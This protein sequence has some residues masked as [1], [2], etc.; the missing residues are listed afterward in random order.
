VTTVAVD[1]AQRGLPAGTWW[2]ETRDG[3]VAEAAVRPAVIGA[4]SS[5][6]ISGAMW[7]STRIPVTQ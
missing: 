2:V 5:I 6:S 7:Y 1:L 3:V 4:D